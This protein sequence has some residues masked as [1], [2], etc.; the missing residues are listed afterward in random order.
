LSAKDVQ[1][2]TLQGEKAT[3]QG[4]VTTL[5]HEKAAL[6]AKVAELEARL[7]V[8]PTVCPV[9]ENAKAFLATLNLEHYYNHE[10][11][12][13][14]CDRCYKGPSVIANEGPTPYVV[15]RGWVRV[16]LKTPPRMNDPDLEVWKK[17]SVSFHGVKSKPV[18]NS[19]LHH[20]GLMKAGD[21]LH[22]GTRLKSTKCAGRQDKVFYTSPTIKYAG[23]RFYAEPQAWRGG[24][25]QASMVVQCRQNPKSFKTQQETMKF[26]L[27][28][29]GH[30]ARNCPD[31]DLGAIEWKSA[32][33]LGAI[34]YGLLVR[35]WPTGADPDIGAYTSPVDG[36]AAGDA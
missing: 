12:R 5:E 26:E 25:M 31:V 17:W 15:P 7:L 35:V 22:D 4:A 2:A 8:D 36:A 11:D 24:D 23:L 30:L 18:L 1:I 34:P 9:K 6:H 21:T 20:G 10:F 14:Y 27:E 33:N 28:M 13:C 29:K 16:G 32:A 3:L 19:I